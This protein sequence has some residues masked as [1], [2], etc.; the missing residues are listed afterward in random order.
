MIL[1]YFLLFLILYTSAAPMQ[2]IFRFCVM[3]FHIM[4]A[5]N[6]SRLHIIFLLLFGRD[7]GGHVSNLIHFFFRQFLFVLPN[8]K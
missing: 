5:S 1:V 6:G 2:I 3:L 8:D 7:H 4:R